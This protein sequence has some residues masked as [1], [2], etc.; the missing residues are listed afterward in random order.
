MHFYTNRIYLFKV[1]IVRKLLLSISL[2]GTVKEIKKVKKNTSKAFYKKEKLMKKACVIG[3]GAVGLPTALLAAKAG[4]KVIGVDTDPVRISR[5]NTGA[6]Y[7]QFPEFVDCPGDCGALTSLYAT[8]EYE[9]ADYFIIT[10]PVSVSRDYKVNV[11]SFSTI[12]SDLADIIKKDAVIILE[13]K[14]PV[15]VTRSF[16]DIIA[17][18]SGLIA[19]VDFFVAYCPEQMR[20]GNTLAQI[21]IQDR[22]IGGINVESAKKAATWYEFFT[23]GD[24]YLTTTENAEIAALLEHSFMQ[25]HA[26]FANTIAL[27]AQK[28]GCNPYELIELANKNP[29]VTIQNPGSYEEKSIASSDLALLCASFPKET[30]LLRTA[31]SV[32]EDYNKRLQDHII[33]KVTAMITQKGSLSILILGIT[34]PSS[35]TGIITATAASIIRLLADNEAI[36]LM[37]CDPYLVPSEAPYLFQKHLVTL[38]HGIEKADMF[39]ALTAHPEFFVIDPSLFDEKTTLD[40]CG[41]WHKRC[42]E[43]VDQEQ[44]FWSK[45]DTIQEND[46]LT[47]K[48]P[49]RS[50]RPTP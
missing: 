24:L 34:S 39:I 44:L 8:T 47:L 16:A 7:E 10:V 26:S 9:Q 41:L 27:I 29:Q 40:F 48:K 2:R 4:I 5:I 1:K 43:T 42:K 14:I 32:H 35:F 37:I 28:H 36:N 31:Q 45:R 21:Q 19:G 30:E 49:T 17:E 33:E 13:S 6:F 22:V 12:A 23:S 15:G 25:M 50:R 38:A 46:P 18:R 20:K 11:S 3:L